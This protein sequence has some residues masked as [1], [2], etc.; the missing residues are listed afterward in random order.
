MQQHNL[1]TTSQGSLKT[2]T[3]PAWLLPPLRL[4]IDHILV[5]D[6]IDLYR[7]TVMGN[8]GSDHLPSVA[9]IGLH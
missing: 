9:V 5:S 1:K 7:A 4:P 2:G 6:K 8:I 3:Y